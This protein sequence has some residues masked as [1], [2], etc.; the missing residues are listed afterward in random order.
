M[1][2]ES[3]VKQRQQRELA[4]SII[5]KVQKELENPKVLQQILQ[6]SVADVESE[7]PITNARLRE[8]ADRCCRDRRFQGSIGNRTLDLHADSLLLYSVHTHPCELA[9]T[10]LSFRHDSV[11]DVICDHESAVPGWLCCS[12][13]T[14]VYSRRYLADIGILVTVSQNLHNTVGYSI[15]LCKIFECSCNRIATD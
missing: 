3:Q 11:A 9:N 5:A 4:Q 6:Q 14:P 1:R 7:F 13:E 10:D 8:R 2:Y 12:C 15:T